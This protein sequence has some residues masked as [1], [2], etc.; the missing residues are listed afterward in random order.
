MNL[1]KYI[2]PCELDY[3]LSIMNTLVTLLTLHSLHFAFAFSGS[4]IQMRVVDK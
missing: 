2:F 4:I 3:Q 1:Y